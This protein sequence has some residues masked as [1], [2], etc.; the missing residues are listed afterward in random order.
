MSFQ[1]L[2]NLGDLYYEIISIYK[3]FNHET[4]M[5]KDL[6]TQGNDYYE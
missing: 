2:K 6:G 3:F 1:L 4:S 5:Y